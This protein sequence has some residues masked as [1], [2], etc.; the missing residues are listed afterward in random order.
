MSTALSWVVEDLDKKNARE[1]KEIARLRRECRDV[2]QKCHGKSQKEKDLEAL[3]RR[4][5]EEDARKAAE[6][7]DSLARLREQ[8]RLKAARQKGNKLDGILTKLEKQ[9]ERERRGVV[10]P[11]PGQFLRRQS[12]L[13]LPVARPAEHGSRLQGRV[14][15]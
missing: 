9:I 12:P 1:H 5:A 13:S 11:N 14:G 8:A 7:V 10:V 3:E 15:A 4:L 6:E 2:T